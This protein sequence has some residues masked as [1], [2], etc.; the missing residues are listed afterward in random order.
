MRLQQ[1]GISHLSC[2]TAV[3]LESL[4]FHSLYPTDNNFESDPVSTYKLQT[5]SHSFWPCG[6]AGSDTDVDC[7]TVISDASIAG[8]APTPEVDDSDRAAGEA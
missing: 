1:Q 5:P 3:D 6:G 2:H 8:A 7:A 4:F